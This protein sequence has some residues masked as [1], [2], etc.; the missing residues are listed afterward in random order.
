MAD[1][2]TERP[3]WKAD[4]LI[5][6]PIVRQARAMEYIAHYL[7]RIEQHLARLADASEQSRASL[8]GIAQTLP[9]LQR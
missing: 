3:A 5:S 7:D 8:I 9:P 4:P 6:D 2:A 1:Q